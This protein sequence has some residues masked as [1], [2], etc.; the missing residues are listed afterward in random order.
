MTQPIIEDGLEALRRELDLGQIMG[1]IESTARWVSPETFEYLPLWYPEHARKAHYYKENWSKPQMN[2][3]RTNGS[4]VHKSEGNV[5][6]NKALTSAL[7]LRKAERPNWTCCHLWGVD[8]GAYQIENSIVQDARYF[9]CV[10]NMV[11]LPTPLKAFTDVMH[12]VKMRLRVCATH[13]YG[14]HCDHPAISS[15]AQKVLEWND[16][17]DYPKSWP[18]SERSGVP[19][20]VVP[21]S[22]RIK[23]LADRRKRSIRKDLDSAGPHYPRESVQEALDYWHIKL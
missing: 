9:S 17:S 1:L 21:F 20:G 4:E 7:G 5:H 16:W 19:L 3:N 12:E 10:G 15:S 14:W 2:K 22:E 23:Q 8:D 6:A 18:K 13:L 11:L